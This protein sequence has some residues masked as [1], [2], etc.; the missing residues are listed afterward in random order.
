MGKDLFAENNQPTHATEQMLS[1]EH[2]RIIAIERLKEVISELA[3]SDEFHNAYV[4]NHASKQSTEIE[5]SVIKTSNQVNVN[6]DT[7]F[8]EQ[9][10]LSASI[11]RVICAS[12]MLSPEEPLTYEH[13][14][15]DE[16]HNKD[17]VQY[18][19]EQADVV[20]PT[21]ETTSRLEQRQQHKKAKRSF[22]ILTLIFGFSPIAIIV[23]IYFYT[24]SLIV[25][26]KPKPDLGEK[27]I[28]HL[29]TGE[30]VFTYENLIVYEH[31]K[32]Y[33]EGERNTIDLTGGKVVYEEWE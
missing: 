26:E 28:I 32:L 21:E 11:H 14:K 22:N 18:Q 19:T 23:A 16:L 15:T 1:E 27:V 29:P 6:Q 13:I 31:G 17:E 4:E 5:Q 12:S 3:K 25:I 10:D 33:Y 24:Q 20:Q 30:T 2:K 8:I 9:Y 7:P